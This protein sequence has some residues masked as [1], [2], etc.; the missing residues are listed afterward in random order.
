M[1]EPHYHVCSKRSKLISIRTSMS[2]ESELWMII[3][4]SKYDAEEESIIYDVHFCPFCSA[5][6][7]QFSK[8][9]EI[10][11]RRDI[12]VVFDKGLSMYSI[13]FIQGLERAVDEFLS[14]FGYVERESEKNGERAELIWWQTATTLS[15]DLGQPKV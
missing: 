1:F 8:G 10:I 2:G 7:P 4:K 6:L 5:R 14:R 12:V 15:S 9:Q 3:Q 11:D 13:Q